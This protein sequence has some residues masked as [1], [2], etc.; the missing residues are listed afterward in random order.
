MQHN[1]W[2]L[3]LAAAGA[4]AGLGT[5]AHA[6]PAVVAPSYG[7]GVI[8]QTAPPPPLAEYV[9]PARPGY[10]WAPGHYELRDGRYEWRGGTWVAERP[11][12]VWQQAQWVQ[13]PDGSWVLAGNTWVRHGPNG[14]RDGDGIANRYDRDSRYNPNGDIDADGIANRHDND[15]DGDGHANWD[16]NYP[17][18]PYR[19]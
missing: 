13:R 5:A 10:V 9:P 11:G 7:P 2:I 15:R 19:S 1:K 8:V 17:N 12:H 14:D 18:N 3:S 4:L 16:D 6:V